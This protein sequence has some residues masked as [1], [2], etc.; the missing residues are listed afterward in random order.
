MFLFNYNFKD[1][2]NEDEIKSQRL[3]LIMPAITKERKISHI[4]NFDET[5]ITI[6]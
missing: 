5:K 1:H 6:K 2:S 3:Q 4:S